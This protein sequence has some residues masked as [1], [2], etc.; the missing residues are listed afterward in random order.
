MNQ[1][2]MNE[3]VACDEGAVIE[4]VLTILAA[5]AKREATVVQSPQQTKKQAA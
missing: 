2:T 3:P 1:P 5:I 4:Q